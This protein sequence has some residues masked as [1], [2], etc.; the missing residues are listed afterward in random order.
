M[1]KIY[2]N[3]LNFN[4]MD[5]FSVVIFGFVVG[6]V[7]FLAVRLSNWSQSKTQPASVSSMPEQPMPI[8]PEQS[9]SCEPSTTA[10]VRRTG[11]EIMQDFLTQTACQ[12]DTLENCDEWTYHIFVYQG[13]YF[14]SYSHNT[15]DE[16]LVYYHWGVP[17][18]R[19]NYA[20][21]QR[22][23]NHLSNKS[24][25]VRTT[26][27]YDADNDK[28]DVILQIATINPTFDELKF[29]FH[30]IF[31][32]ARELLTEYDHR[33]DR[34]EEDLLEAMRSRALFLRCQQY[35]EPIRIM[36]NY[37][38]FNANQLS[39]QQVL[40]SLFD[41]EQVEDLLSMTIVSEQG[42]EQVFQRDQIASF[43]LFSTIINKVEGQLQ[44]SSAPVAI[45]LDTTFFHYTFTLHLVEQTPENIF[46][47]LT[48]MKVPYDHLQTTMPDQVYTPESVS[49]LLCYE[50]SDEHS[51]DTFGRK[52]E[53][54][55]QAKREGQELTDEQQSLL[56][57]TEG[58][59]EYQLLEGLRLAKHGCYLQAIALLEPAFRRLSRKDN[60]LIQSRY[61]KA[62]DAAY[63]LGRCYYYLNQFNK[64]Y[65]Y[66]HT[67]FK[68]NRIDSSYIYFQLLYHSQDIHFLNELL[69]EKQKMENILQDMSKR[70]EI[71]TDDEQLQYN[72]IRD[73]YLFLYKLHAETMIREKQYQFAYN[74]L[75]YLLQYEQTQEYAQAKIDEL[76]KTNPEL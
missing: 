22:I 18:S 56:A 8:Q 70:A 4:I 47:R 35:N 52:M 37:K 54:A 75:N 27:R 31:D 11:A 69:E 34:T 3:N 64:A 24:R 5:L 41:A 30:S 9:P 45:T 6:L 28:F 39:M 43:D 67:A 20:W 50:T 65:F 36:A 53:Q 55:R 25:Y 44:T 71:L 14:E 12:I 48:A 46:I 76:D 40:T 21:V 62:I 2:T 13:A 42:S 1:R 15:T 38:H 19:E 23:C 32:V 73:Y 51:F 72:N 63:H 17:Y 68:A 10:P 26:H 60:Q 33:D 49:C 57:L 29:H 58:N 74:D 66:I 61:D 59:L 7:I 16:I